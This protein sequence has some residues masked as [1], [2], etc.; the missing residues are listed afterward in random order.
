MNECEDGLFHLI[1]S[2]LRTKLLLNFFKIWAKSSG[3]RWDNELLDTAILKMLQMFN[4]FS[5]HL[6]ND[7]SFVNIPSTYYLL[8]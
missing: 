1:S 2:G 4:V 8:V 7:D 3:I 5:L 6:V